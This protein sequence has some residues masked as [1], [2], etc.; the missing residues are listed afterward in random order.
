M[1]HQE[2]ADRGAEAEGD[3][4]ESDATVGERNTDQRDPLHEGEH[5]GER[6][7][8]EAVGKGAPDEPPDHTSDGDRR[9]REGAGR[10]VDAFGAEIRDLGETADLGTHR[11]DEADEHDDEETGADGDVVLDAVDRTVVR[12]VLGAFWLEAPVGR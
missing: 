11:Q 2:V 7:Q 12:S 1:E 10:G 4:H 3:D 8:R 9:H 5:D 6:H